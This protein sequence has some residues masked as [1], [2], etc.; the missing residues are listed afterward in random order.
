MNKNPVSIIIGALLLVV[1]ATL[2]FVFQ[3]RQAEIAVVTRF[4]KP[5]RTLEE[6]GGPRWRL[7]WPIERV[8]KFDQRVQ[9]YEDK[10]YQ[11]QTADDNQVLTQLYVGWR[12]TDAPV[13]FPRFA[14]G[15]MVEAEKVLQERVRSAKSAVIGRRALSDFVSASQPVKLAEIEADIL[16]VVREQ[17]QANNYG[18]DVEF[19]GFMKVGLPESVTQSVFDRMKADRNVLSTNLIAQGEAE[20]R[21]IRSA[22]E[23]EAATTLAKA[24]AEATRIRSEGEA[25][26][27]EMLPIF[28]QEPELASFLLR[29]QALEDTLTERTTLIFDQN[30]PPFDLLGTGITNAM[31]PKR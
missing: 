17:L 25:A 22:A 23:R 2:L 6:P 21:K 28:Q 29:L 24:E 31:R 8:Y 27:A 11:D 12:V 1:F 26:A 15:S 16:K 13:F 4:G 9:T 30:N 19:L 7:P 5:V 20:A 14:N 3:V 10:L 18:M